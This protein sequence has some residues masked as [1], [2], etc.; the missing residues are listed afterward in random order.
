M[1]EKIKEELILDKI[2]IKEEE[3]IIEEEICSSSSLEETCTWDVQE[4]DV[5]M[6]NTEIKGKV[7]FQVAIVLSY[8]TIS[9]GSFNVC[10]NT[11]RKFIMTLMCI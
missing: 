10:K 11:C 3:L 9:P 5:K 1:A 7:P 8:S 2:V 4:E 6:E